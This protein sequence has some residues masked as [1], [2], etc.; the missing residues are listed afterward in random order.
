MSPGYAAAYSSAPIIDKYST[1]YIHPTVTKVIQ[2]GVEKAAPYNYDAYNAY[3][4]Y[5]VPTQFAKHYSYAAPAPAYKVA[6]PGKF[7]M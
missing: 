5:A 7:D 3:A 6:A 1:D 2:P 4:K